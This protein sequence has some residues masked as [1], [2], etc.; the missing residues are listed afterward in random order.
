MQKKEPKDNSPLYV[1]ERLTIVLRPEVSAEGDVPDTY[2]RQLLRV[3][4]YQ[5][6]IPH[7][8]L[9]GEIGTKSLPL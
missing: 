6:E 7:K 2:L 9:S 3:E 1:R 8:T 5:E 4:F